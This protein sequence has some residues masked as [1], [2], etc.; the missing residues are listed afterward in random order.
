MTSQTDLSARPQKVTLAVRLL[1]FVVAIGVLRTGMTVM[2]HI[3]VRSPDFLIA[4]KALFYAISI[5]VIYQVG[6]GKNWARWTLV[7]LF[8]V[9][10][11]LTILPAFE[12]FATNPV[13]IGLGFLQLAMYL[14]SLALLFQQSSS[15]WFSI[16]K[17]ALRL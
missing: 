9:H 3:E 1:Y 14:V 4:S 5:L 10:V 17:Q 16:S 13:N 15:H 6:K 2:R 11:P 12:S 8:V 7:G